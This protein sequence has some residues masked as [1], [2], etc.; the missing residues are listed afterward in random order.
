LCPHISS[1]N[2][3][4]FPILTLK[5]TPQ[6]VLFNDEDFHSV[7][8]LETV[9]RQSGVLV[10]RKKCLFCKVT[11]VSI[12]AFVEGLLRFAN[13]LEATKKSFSKVN[14]IF[15]SSL[16]QYKEKQKC[17]RTPCVLTYHPCLRNSFNT[18]RRHLTSVEKTSKLSKV[19]SEP[20]MFAFKQ[21][22]S[23]G[24]LLVRAEMSTPNT[25]IGKSHSCGDKRCKCCKHM[26]HSSSYSSET[27]SQT[28]MVCEDTRCSIT[29]LFFFV[30]K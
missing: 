27:V 28:G 3:K 12:Q 11:H 30:L 24:N 4:S 2:P 19:F 26:Q 10:H 25:T 17:N 8:I 22:N 21:P 29:F 7:E 15:R 18:I 16:L 6:T 23:L 5:I 1:L 14:N 20:P 9:V 13:V